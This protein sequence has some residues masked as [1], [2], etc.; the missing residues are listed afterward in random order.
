MLVGAHVSTNIIPELV[1]ICKE[2]GWETE[3]QRTAK[4]PAGS[5]DPTDGKVAGWETP[6]LPPSDT[7]NRQKIPHWLNITYFGRSPSRFLDLI[8]DDF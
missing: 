5:W 8:F 4:R 3:I 6:L 7:I 1:H 2:A